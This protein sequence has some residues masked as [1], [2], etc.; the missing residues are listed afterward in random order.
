MGFSFQ[1]GDVHVNT[2]KRM[3]VLVRDPESGYVRSCWSE[4]GEGVL[5][6][7]MC[8]QGVVEAKVGAACPACDSKVDRVLEIADGGKP[9]P[10]GRAAQKSQASPRASRGVLLPFKAPRRERA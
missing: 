5:Y 6:C 4:P 8:M 9:R 7:G 1:V 3:Y 2:E 10:I